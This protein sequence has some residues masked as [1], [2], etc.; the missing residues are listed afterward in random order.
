MTQLLFFVTRT[1]LKASGQDGI[2]D[3]QPLELLW[4]PE[5]LPRQRALVYASDARVLGIAGTSPWFQ[6]PAVCTLNRK[7]D[8]VYGFIVKMTE[9]V[10][11]RLLICSAG[12][13]G[14]GLWD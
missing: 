13:V 10:L 2:P 14:F 11:P 5:S 9:K 7:P 6:L 3:A 4:L 1:L 8:R 12:L